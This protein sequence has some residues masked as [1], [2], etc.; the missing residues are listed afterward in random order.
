[1]EEGAGVLAQI[2]KIETVVALKQRVFLR[3][4]D[5]QTDKQTKTMNQTLE[6]KASI[7]LLREP[8]GRIEQNPTRSRTTPILEIC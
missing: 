1:M 4:Y 6:I 2:F 5:S 3:L 7:P 8:V